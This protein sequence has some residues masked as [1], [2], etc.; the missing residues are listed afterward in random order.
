MSG[1]LYDKC[2][3]WKWLYRI[4]YNYDYATDCN[5]NYSIASE[6]FMQWRNRFCNSYSFRRNWT[7]HLHVDTRA[8]KCFHRNRTYRWKLF[9]HSN[10]CEWLYGNNKFIYINTAACV[11]NCCAFANQCY[12]QWRL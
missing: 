1:N 10:G 6:Y 4:K 11:D 12:L 3:G 7:I 2:D 9:L 5:H 8:R